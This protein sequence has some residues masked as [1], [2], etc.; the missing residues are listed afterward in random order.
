MRLKI[1]LAVLVTLAATNCTTPAAPPPV[2]TTISAKPKL[3][4]LDVAAEAAWTS[5]GTSEARLRDGTA[6]AVG[7][8]TFQVIDLASG[9][10]RWKTDENTGLGGGR[11]DT[12]V[13]TPFLVGEGANLAVLSAYYRFGQDNEYGLV[14]LSAMD[15]RVLWQKTTGEHLF[16]HAADERIALVTTTE[17]ATLTKPADLRMIAFE[18]RTGNQLWERTGAWPAAI[19]GNTVLGVNGLEQDLPLDAL[20]PG[21]S[22]FA[23]DV[24]TGDPRWDIADRYEGSEVLL[25]AGEV[26][27]VRG[28]ESTEDKAELVL[29]SA[30][31]GK[32]VVDIGEVTANCETDG[33]ATIVCGSE[34]D[35]LSVFR[36]ADQSVTSVPNDDVVEAVWRDRIFVNAIGDRHY[37]VD[38]AGNEIDRIPGAPVAVSGDYLVVHE[39]PRRPALVGYPLG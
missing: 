11:W 30:G 6:L 35:T 4:K 38:L 10:V 5:D 28:T 14:L 32:R 1:V 25:T 15:G 39:N 8:K 3:P 9:A 18:T 34:D 17:V 12:R 23:F 36:L 22:V 16:L 27:L 13:G 20:G 7:Q 29:L 2:P 37:T 24:A 26:V 19:A 31:T 21:P 33:E